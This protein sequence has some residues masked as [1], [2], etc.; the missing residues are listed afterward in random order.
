MVV[1]IIRINN[2]HTL[3]HFNQGTLRPGKLAL[4]ITKIPKGLVS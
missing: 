3:G 1:I 2:L 4:N